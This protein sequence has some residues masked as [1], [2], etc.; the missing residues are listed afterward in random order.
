MTAVGKFFHPNQLTIFQE[1]RAAFEAKAR[2]G[3]SER[4]RRSGTETPTA[5]FRGSGT[6]EARPRLI[7]NA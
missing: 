4:R 6:E 2:R 3:K 5:F 1:N 7:I